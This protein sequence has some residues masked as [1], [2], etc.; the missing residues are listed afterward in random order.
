MSEEER[1][2]STTKTAALIKLRDYVFNNDTET[3]HWSSDI[4][5]ESPVDNLVRDIGEEEEITSAENEF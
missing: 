2:S 1:I 4:A 5:V 3:F